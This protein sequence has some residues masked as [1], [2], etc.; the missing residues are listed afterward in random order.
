MKELDLSKIL[1]KE[2]KKD[3][4]FQEQFTMEISRLIWETL[5]A[6]WRRARGIQV[7]E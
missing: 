7:F 4:N 2:G 1:F 3:Q 6:I 5:N